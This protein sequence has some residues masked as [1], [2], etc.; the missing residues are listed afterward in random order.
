MGTYDEFLDA[1]GGP[2]D[3]WAHI[4]TTLQQLGHDDLLRR[5][6]DVNRLLEADGVSYNT[7]EGNDPRRNRWAL[8]PLP[9]VLSSSEWAEV[10]A[11]II[12]RAELFALILADLYGPRD[13]IRRGLLPIEMVYDHPGFLRSC[14]QIG[15]GTTAPMHL[16]LYAADLARR[17]DGRYV[18][19]VDRAQAPSGAGYALENRLVVSRVFPSLYRD[20]HVHRLAPFFRSLRTTLREAAP[21]GS[22]NR[23]DPRVVV[24]TPGSWSETAFEHAYIASYLGYSLVQG[25]DL[26]ARGGRIWMR[27]LGRSEP[28]DVILRRVDDVFCDPLELR[29]ESQLGVPGLVDAARRNTV[30]IV[31]PLGSG[32]IESPAMLA[33]LPSV[34]QHYLGRPLQLASVPTWWCGDVESRRYVLA[35]LSSLILKPSARS[36]G[37]SAI[38]GW[39]MSSGE[40]DDLRGR[41][42]ASPTQWTAQEAVEKSTTPTLTVSGVEPRRSVLR[43]FAV[44]R[45]DTYTVMPGGL[46][47][48][49]ADVDGQFI[50]NQAGALSKDVW[51]LASEPESV[52]SLWLHSGPTV[53]A[54]D[55]TGSMPSRAA[56]NLFWLGRYAERAESVVRL[57][58][59]VLDRR[60]EFASDLNPAGT[61]CFRIL[62]QAVT[63]VASA[64][65]G[66]TVPG[67]VVAPG[68]EL[69]ALIV[70]EQRPGTIA[71]SVR[72][73]LDAAYA[74]RDQLSNDTWLVIG[75]VDREIIEL[76]D[77]ADTN[78]PVPL[79]R[80][81][82]AAMQSLLALSGLAS[83]SMVRDPGWHFMDAGRRLERSMQLVS[84]LRSTVVTVNDNAT[85]SLLLESVLISAESIIT[86]RRRYRSQAQMETLLDLLLL[87]SGN[88]RSLIYQLDQL[89]HSLARLPRPDGQGLT[90]VDRL[91]IEATSLVRL[92]DTARLSMVD[93]TGDRSALGSFLDAL[94]GLLRSCAEAIDRFHFAPLLPQRSIGGNR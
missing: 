57:L 34:A 38:L 43:T 87:D 65:P 81:L 64:Y 3:H 30:S 12:E 85:E 50:S 6:A 46:L 75:N 60:N 44:A 67:P 73:L 40:L 52:T 10:E 9:M 41:I 56:E 35:N 59:V 37:R 13:L 53:E 94:Y 58:R 55:P 17:S 4:G 32:I 88:P 16:P 61:A 42:E 63:Q 26:M 28:V 39:E 5:Q 33:F 89:A 1:Q 80:T 49:A 91:M 21:T 8:D 36:I 2:R 31:N 7:F 71:H 93:G 77:Q 83:E 92:A 51:V 22:P 76:R 45:G 20:A 86:Y 62:L 74:V 18:A 11:G 78:Q 19:L 25:S 66:F 69:F 15:I 48:V 54:I 23:S 14:D 29:P 70:D 24:L 79:Q 82:A 72:R 68:P 27:S 47:R 90:D 84:V